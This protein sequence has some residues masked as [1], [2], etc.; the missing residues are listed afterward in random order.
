MSKQYIADKFTISGGTTSQFLKGDGSLDTN[1][2]LTTSGNTRLLYNDSSTGLI[3]GGTL[4]TATTTTFNVSAGSG[5]IVDNATDPFNPVL[6]NVNWTGFTNQTALNVGTEPA[7]YLLVS[8]GGT[9]IKTNAIPKS[10]DIRSGILLGAIIS[11]GTAITSTHSAVVN[12]S[13]PVA[14]L[15]DLANSIGLFSISGNKI[16][17]NV[18]NLTLNKSA[19]LSFNMGG[20]FYVDR[21]NPNLLVSSALTAPNLLYIKQDY[22]LTA[23]TSSI[24]TNNYD[25][26]GV[27]TPLA[28]GRFAA[29][30]I[31]FR[32]NSN[33]IIFQYGQASYSS[34]T[35][36]RQFE[37]ED[38]ITP[39]SL[40][41]FAY[42]VAVIIVKKGETNLD[43]STNC[44]IIPQGKFAGTGGAGGATP[45]LQLVYDAST[46]PEIVTDSIRNALTLKNGSGPDSTSNLFE[47]MSSGGTVTSAIRANGFI[48]GN[49][50]SIGGANSVSKL[51]INTGTGTASTINITG[52]TNGSIGFA[53][54]SSSNQ[55]P[56][57]HGKSND[58]VGLYFMGTS[59]EDNPN[60]DMIFNVRKNTNLDF[61]GLTSA[62]YSFDRYTTNLAT[63]LRNGNTAIGTAS[64]EGGWK[65]VVEGIT[66]IGAPY[67]NSRLYVSGGA[68]YTNVQARDNVLPT[69]M[70]YI[71][72]SHTFDTSVTISGVTSLIGNV[73]S[74]GIY[75]NT[76]ASASNIGISA[77]GDIYRSTSSLRYKKNVEDYSKGIDDLMRLRPVS[78]ESIN[79]KEEGVKYAGLIA[80]EVDSLGFKEFVQYDINGLPD[81]LAY[82]NM[83]TIL[84]KAVQEQQVQINGLKEEIIAL[85]NL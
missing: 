23:N 44:E 13:S 82:Q 64:P 81:A 11:L 70:R 14:Q 42:L 46:N 50:V 15:A 7:T 31:W 69:Q 37:S 73:F 78:F 84:I 62:A 4:T 2:Y 21:T 77:G 41:T 30:R 65:F 61:T 38:Y 8:S 5:I 10:N 9:L 16:S 71:A 52:Q 17:N 79:E 6:I 83:V 35:L 43:N 80:E 68:G 75:T 29:H 51:D 48:S 85:K 45:T 1:S 28:G 63:I 27:I 67:G 49:S 56:L 33:R 22:F 58:S 40:T 47:G 34:L 25:L 59:V 39:P 72:S 26:N 76:S 3:S 18:G 12:V 54:G 57:I 60:A 32:P 55:V 20:N 19:G 36:A 53:N 24:D 66:A 74:N